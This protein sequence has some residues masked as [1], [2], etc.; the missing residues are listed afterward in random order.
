M[1]NI[2]LLMLRCICI[3]IVVSMLGSCIKDIGNYDYKE[4]NE[5]VEVSNLPEEMQ[6][7]YGKKLAFVPV[8][9]FSKDPDFDASKY[10]YEWS[11]IG[12][13]G[14]G[15]TGLY[16]LSDAKDL[17]MVLTK[18]VA[19][20][21]TA[22]FAI[23][24]KASG[25]KYKKS[26]KLKV[27]NEYNEG[28][29]MMNEVNGK[30][31][32]DMLY[33]DAER[34]FKLVNDVLGSTG[35]GLTLEGK[36]VLA[37]TY[38]TGL[39]IGPDQISYGVYL[40]TDKYTTKVDP[41]TFKWTPTMGLSYEM[42]GD[43]PVGFYAE[44]IQVRGGGSSAYMIGGGEAYYYDRTMQIYFSAPISYNNE[45]QK[46]FKVAPFVAASSSYGIFYDIT[47]RRFVKHSG[48][49]STTT[50]L[51]DPAIGQRLFSFTT[52]KDL[53]YMRNVPY[54]GGEVF[55]ILKDVNGSKKYLAR[56]NPANNAQ[57][58]Y[59]EIIGTDIDKAEFYA[60]NPEFGYVFYSVGSKVYQY[61]MTY[62]TT[63]LMADYGSYKISYLDFYEFKAT[64][65]INAEGKRLMVGTY[66]ATI[67]N[68]T[69]GSLH[70]Y[71]VPS[72]NGD[73][74]EIGTYS[75]FGR[76]KSLTYRER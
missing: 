37:Y 71:T 38:S 11:Y 46:S 21:Y 70:I 53:V 64:A 13:N 14:L 67:N 5:L 36:P 39:L 54:N 42:Y 72:L 31:R 75:G 1:K 63:K 6:A 30:A 24:D 43:V 32:V 62:K 68:G 74:I 2:Y 7:Q 50:V 19:G 66:D 10:A 56:F 57:T 20:T 45:D 58:Y 15:G 23:T 27:V 9:K 48:T 4:L 52:G 29:I 49:A 33:L 41:N 69:E 61:D 34:N 59:A 65:K 16:V 73:L 22:Y 28:W 25:V 12:P 76:I 17:D 35:A 47:N 18:V 60:V 40:G 55:S 3:L 44:R 51:P 26:F 8:I